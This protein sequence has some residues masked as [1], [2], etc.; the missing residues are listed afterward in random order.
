M[1]LLKYPAHK[2]YTYNCILLYQ[3]WA[4][5]QAN[6]LIWLKKTY[7]QPELSNKKGFVGQIGVK[8]LH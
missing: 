4:T 8:R 2:E 1:S 6:S 7:F 3:G 5:S